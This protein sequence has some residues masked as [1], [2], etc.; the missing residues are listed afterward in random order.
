MTNSTFGLLFFEKN[1]I[2]IF[3]INYIGNYFKILKNII[4]FKI[5]K[6]PHIHNLTLKKK[7]ISLKISLNYFVS[8]C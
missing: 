8:Y 7:I 2:F 1:Y 4:L 6:M 3:Y 5:I